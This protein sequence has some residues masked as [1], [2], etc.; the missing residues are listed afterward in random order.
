MKRNIV[1]S[2]V[3]IGAMLLINSSCQ[4]RMQ[5]LSM[6]KEGL[7]FAFYNVENLFDTINDPTINDEEF[8]PDGKNNWDTKKYKHKLAQM[9]RVIAAMDTMSYPD[10]LGLAEVE[11]KQVLEDLVKQP[12][13]KAANYQIIHLSDDDP[14]GIEVAMLYRK[15]FFRP[16]SVKAIQIVND[17]ITSP[18]RHILYVKGTVATGDTLHLFVN[19]W[20]SRYGGEE[21]TKGRRWASGKTIRSIADSLFAINRNSNLIIAGDLNDNPTDPSLVSFMQ[22]KNPYDG[23]GTGD[24]YN[25]SLKPYSNGEGTLYY[26]SWD[27]FDQVIVSSNLL[28]PN[29][30]KLQVSDL[31]IIKKP[32]MLFQPKEGDARPNRTLSGSRYFGGYSDHLPVM[33]RL[34]ESR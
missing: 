12:A 32:W 1:F 25:L 15:E 20:A 29:T 26:K 17:S 10:M 34:T 16:A 14:R 33:V 11:N 3:A 5:Q 9:A 21:A 28:K 22:A 18:L 30:G 24:L 8:L 31:I 19:H 27:L 23:I 13:I 6:P 7:T 4:Q 2:L